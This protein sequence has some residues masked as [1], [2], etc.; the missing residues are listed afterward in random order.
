MNN[1]VLKMVNDKKK[2]PNPFQ[3]RTTLHL[4]PF[5]MTIAT[6]IGAAWILKNRIGKISVDEN[7]TLEKKDSNIINEEKRF[8]FFKCPW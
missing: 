8:Q 6:G 1:E 2:I 5:A 7:Q 4:F 3:Y